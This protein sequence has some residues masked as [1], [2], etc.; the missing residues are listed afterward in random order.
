MNKTM[1]IDEGEEEVEEVLIVE[2]SLGENNKKQLYISKN[3]DIQDVAE[4]FCST[5]GNFVN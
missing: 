5:H 3:D 1:Q 4:K 2:V